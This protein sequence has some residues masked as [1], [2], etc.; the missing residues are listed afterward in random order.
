MKTPFFVF[1]RVFAAMSIIVLLSSC[2]DKALILKNKD[3]RQRLSE[4]ERKVD[5]LEVDAGEDPGDQTEAIKTANAE[6]STALK[7]L[8]DLDDEKERLEAT[9]L[10]KEKELR[11]YKKTYQIK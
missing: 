5:I 9:H 3:L 10:K 4:L 11:N 1:C 6:L 2:E 7:K 8:K